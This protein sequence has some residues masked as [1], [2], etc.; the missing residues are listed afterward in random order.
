LKPDD[1]YAADRP[2]ALSDAVKHDAAR[3]YVPN[4]ASNTVS[5]ID[6]AT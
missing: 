6:P 1:L 5:V 4:L 2:N 3:V